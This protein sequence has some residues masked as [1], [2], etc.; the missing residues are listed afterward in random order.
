MTARPTVASDL[1]KEIL[2]R[3]EKD[4]SAAFLG[5]GEALGVPEEHVLRAVEGEGVRRV[6]PLDAERLVA[7]AKGW[8]RVRVVI[9]NPGAVAE[10]VTTLEGTTRRGPWWNLH[11]AEM[12]FHVSVERIASA[13]FVEKPGH[14]A[15]ITYSLQCFDES[16][17]AVAKLFLVRDAAGE[18]PPE[19]LAAFRASREALCG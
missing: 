17:A 12:E 14:A 1:R 4:A 3:L 19:A 2:A 8:G 15:R 7:E 10:L 6:F 11:A 5:I 16:G 13:Y 18:F 9:R